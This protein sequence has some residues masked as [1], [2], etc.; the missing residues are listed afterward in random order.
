MT[1]FQLQKGDT[2]IPGSLLFVILDG[3]GL[4][5]GREKGYEGNALDLAKAPVLKN[6]LQTTKVQ[7][8]L[9]AHGTAVGLPS[10]SDMGNSEVG[11]NA[12]GA[13]RIFDQGAKLVSKALETGALFQGEG[14]S[15]LIGSPQSP[16]LA[17]EKGK[18]RAV[19]FLGL[20]SDG[21]VHSHIDHLIAMIDRC[22]ESGVKRLYVHTLLD[23]R[24]VEEMSALQYIQTLEETLAK[25]RNRGLDYAIASG[26]GR[27]K[28]TMDRYEADWE[29]VEQGWKTHVKG[30]GNLFPSASAAVES[31]RKEAGHIVD[32]DL[33][34]FVVE[35]NGGALAPIRDDD[36][37][38]LF[39]FRGD[40]AIEISR[41]FTEEKFDKFRRDPSVHVHFAGMMEYDGDLHI[42]PLYLVNPPSISRT[43]SEYL[44]RNGITQYAISETQ[45]FGHVTYFWNGNNSE[46]FDQ[47]K[48]T[49]VEIPSDRISFDR[50]PAMKAPEIARTLI[51]AM[52]S[53]KHRFLRVNFANGDMVGHTGVLEAAV[54]AMEAVD[55]ALGE[56]LE[57]A[58][59]TG[60]TVIVTADH[61]N[62]EE[63][64]QVDK[65]SGQGKRDETGHYIAKTSHTLNHVPFLLTGP[66]SEGYR[67]DTSLSHPGLGNLASTILL[68]LGYRPPEDYLPSLI[69][70]ADA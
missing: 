1:D 41:A 22:G 62:C 14:W 24:D 9:M 18:D 55:A 21:N 3:V 45:K 42:P 2:G 56:L 66:G 70:P 59:K 69:L 29:M 26:G 7:T 32:Q 53:K 12:M 44:A 65:K 15:R 5:P 40:R 36:V 23:G 67:I 46:K 19:H 38:I 17:L 61:G 63:M 49:W 68:L 58:K 31:F 8:T 35:R 43:V 39:N 16:G 25:Y 34:P 27:M 6:L 57:V 30:E 37:V 60:T 47:E 20:L 52:E 50:A 33:P 48:E 28:I 64:Y 54:S 51:Q 13:G 10:D 4:H 11:H